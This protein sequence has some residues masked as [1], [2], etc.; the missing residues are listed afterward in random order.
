MIEQNFNE[1]SEGFQPDWVSPTGDT[2]ADLLEEKGW[3]QAEFA[4]RIGYTHKHISQLINGKATVT[5]DAAIKLERVLGSSARFWLARETQYRE[6]IARAEALDALRTQVHWL[7]QLPLTDMIKFGW[8]KSYKDKGQQVAECLSF[9]GVASV[10]TWQKHYADP[11]AAFKAS[12]T[13]K[14]DGA[15]V[16]AWLR[17]GER[18]A[19]NIMCK[20]FVKTAF[21][22]VLHDLRKLSNEPDPRKFVPELQKA[23]ADVG[24]AVV[25]EPAPKGCPVSGA[26]RWL[27]PNKALLMLSLRHKTNDH[28]WFAF[29]HEAAHLLLHGKKMLFIEVTGL[30]DKHEHEANCFARDWLI[31]HDLANQ[32]LS[33][34]KTYAAVET[35]AKKAGIPPAIVVGRMQNEKLIGWNMLNKC[36]VHYKWT[37]S[38]I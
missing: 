13:F 16:S 5:E 24:V 22:Q 12:D 19:D 36:K 20:P 21:K 34:D 6:S 38:T 18:G 4:E 26:T 14:K 1:A 9:F 29:F 23:C 31:P 10:E 7:K 37:H 17:A 8:I 11:V 30:K 32:L 15:A 27:S 35:F 25:L 28:L 33:L 2:I 3:S